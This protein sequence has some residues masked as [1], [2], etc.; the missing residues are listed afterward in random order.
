[1]TR[2]QPIPTCT[3]AAVLRLL[4]LLQLPMQMP[5]QLPK[6]LVPEAERLWLV[7]QADVAA[8]EDD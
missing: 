2:T 5:M 1:M 4:L 7:L 3:A 8:A 6:G